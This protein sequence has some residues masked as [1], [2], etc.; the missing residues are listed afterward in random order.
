M[1]QKQQAQRLIRTWLAAT[2]KD[3]TGSQRDVRGLRHVFPRAYVIA[4][5]APKCLVVARP[6]MD[7]EAQVKDWNQLHGCDVLHDFDW[8]L[9]AGDWCATAYAYTSTGGWTVAVKWPAR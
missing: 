1:T 8:T 3:R 9:Q 7:S 4:R 2:V 6:W 5:P